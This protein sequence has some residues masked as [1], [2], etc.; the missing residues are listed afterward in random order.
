LVRINVTTRDGIGG[1]GAMWVRHSPGSWNTDGRKP[2][3]LIGCVDCNAEA[4]A[5]NPSSGWF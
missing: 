5:T 1:R 2:A 4:R 3:R